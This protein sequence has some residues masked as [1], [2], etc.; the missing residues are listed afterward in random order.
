MRRLAGAAR[1]GRAFIRL[2]TNFSANQNDPQLP[3]LRERLNQFP[4]FGS[5]MLMTGGI[6]ES[7]ATV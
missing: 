1:Q 7:R 3:M 5:D 2:Q 6:G 4:F